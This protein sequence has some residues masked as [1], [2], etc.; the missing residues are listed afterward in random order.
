MLISSKNNLNFI[1]ITIDRFSVLILG[2]LYITICARHLG[3]QLFGRMGYFLSFF[4][5]LALFINFGMDLH[6]VVKISKNRK[7]LNYHVTVNIIDRLFFFSFFSFCLWFLNHTGIMEV[8][9]VAGLIW[10]AYG[11]EALK[12]IPIF[13]FQAM[14]EMHNIAIFNFIYSASMI[15]IFLLFD[16]FGFKLESVGFAMIISS[17]LSC[18]LSFFKAVKLYDINRIKVKF[19][20][21][22]KLPCESWP[23]FANTIITMLIIH[24]DILM[25]NYFIGDHGT[26]IYN[27]AKRIMTA[28]LVFPS[29]LTTVL[30]PVLSKKKHSEYSNRSMIGLT[31]LAGLILGLFLF[32]FAKNGICFV[33]GKEY[34]SAAFILQIFATGLPFIFINYYW[35]TCF[36]AEADYR[37][38]L[39]TNL[40]AL[41]INFLLN[42]VM[43]PL[44][45][46]GGAA[47]A[48]L[49]SILFSFFYL[50]AIR[51]RTVM[52]RQRKSN[53]ER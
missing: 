53:L 20:D 47:L 31:F 14:E 7:L 32:V 13:C 19:H 9:M 42:C 43:I 23:L 1:C 21:L 39:K 46:A 4:S 38:P 45:S 25:I 28:C 40:Y 18:M 16:Q 2:L 24:M 6:A 8:S 5:I 35:G 48:T 49:V 51:H 26:G 33:F 15:F 3:V 44:F 36:V 30:L 10:T 22:L 29:I 37:I 12:Q 17:S 27:V 50:V 41:I 52:T 34:E 11:F